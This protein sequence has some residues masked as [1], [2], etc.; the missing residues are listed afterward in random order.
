VVV[1][2]NRAVPIL[3][4]LTFAFLLYL[5][6]CFGSEQPTVAIEESPTPIAQATPPSIVGPGLTIP[7]SPEEPFFYTIQSD[8][9]LAA[10]ASSFNV[11]LDVILRANPQLDPSFFLAGQEILIPGATTD[12]TVVENLGPE[13]ADGVTVN[14]VIESGDTLGG[15]ANEYTVKLDALIQANPDIDPGNLSVNAILVIPP[16]GTGFAPGELSPRSTPVASTRQ[17][18]DPSLEHTV[19][20]GQFIRL[21]ADLYNVT[22]AQIVEANDLDASGNNIQIGQVL[23]IPPPV[24][25]P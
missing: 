14:H 15:I 23:L 22:P 8:D 17:P 5:A 21:I 4:V 12:N 25:E 16:W 10:I 7:E 13:R 2:Q 3:L 6:G 9:K 24:A 11:P 1:R 20:A 19:E 18:G